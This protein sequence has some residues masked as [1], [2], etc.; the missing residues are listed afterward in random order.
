S[1]VTFRNYNPTLI[2]CL[3]V[4]NPSLAVQKRRCGGRRSETSWR[5]QPRR[6]Q[7]SAP[8]GVGGIHG[9]CV[10]VRRRGRRFWGREKGSLGVGKRSL[11]NIF[12]FSLPYCDCNRQSFVSN[13]CGSD[14]NDS[15]A[16]ASRGIAGGLTLVF[17]CAALYFLALILRIIR[18]IFFYNA[19]R[20]DDIEDV[21]NLSSAGIPL[22]SKDSEGRTALH[23]AAANGHLEIVEY[24]IRNGVDVNASNA[25]NN[26]PLHWA[27]LNGHIEVVKALIL[28][29]ADVSRLNRHE[30]SAVDEAVARGKLEVI[31]AVNA[32]MAQLELSGAQVS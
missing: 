20:Y 23:M 24:L 30:R 16:R 14:A 31:D 21:V 25:E 17:S 32:A 3:A 29:G 26:T 18:F 10:G 1:F 8:G 6:Q 15:D 5:S 27:C 19:A 9:E 7:R 22:D 12:I 4:S 28:G 2:T 11:L 13:T